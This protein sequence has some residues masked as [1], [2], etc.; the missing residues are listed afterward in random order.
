MEKIVI[1]KYKRAFEAWLNNEE[2]LCR[3]IND[4]FHKDIGIQ[5]ISNNV[6]FF[7]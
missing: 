7:Q 1:K 6:N 2:V 5:P 4:D 3:Y